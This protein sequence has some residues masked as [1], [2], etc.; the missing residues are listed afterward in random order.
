VEQVAI[1]WA[2]KKTSRHTAAIRRPT[3][4]SGGGEMIVTVAVKH[5]GGVVVV[6]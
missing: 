6:C 1:A 4:S 3:P 2:D 5:F